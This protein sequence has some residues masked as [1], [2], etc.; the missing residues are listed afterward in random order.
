[1]ERYS[2]FTTS[3]EPYT[4]GFAHQRLTAASELTS[5]LF[6]SE[7]KK[8]W[9]GERTEHRGRRERKILWNERKWV[10][11]LYILLLGRTDPTHFKGPTRAFSPKAQICFLFFIFCTPRNTAAPHFFCIHSFLV[12]FFS[13]FLSYSFSFMHFLFLVA[14]YFYN[15]SHSFSLVSFCICILILSILNY[16]IY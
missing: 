3:A 14:L 16:L 9:G 10:Y 4:C 6:S 11:N 7:K 15:T 12:L 13:I 2:L 1:M 8:Q 5:D